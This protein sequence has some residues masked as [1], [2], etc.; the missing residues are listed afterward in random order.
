M[1]PDKFG[2]SK[3]TNIALTAIIALSASNQTPQT[4]ITVTIIACTAL[5]V[6]GLIDFRKGKNP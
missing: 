6:Q 3:K 5:L 2:I 1:Q 4:C